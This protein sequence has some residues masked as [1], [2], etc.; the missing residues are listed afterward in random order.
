MLSGQ[1]QPIASYEIGS[2]PQL[3]GLYALRVPLDSVG[4]RLPSTARPGDRAKIFLAKI[5]LDGQLTAEVTIG[6]RGTVQ[7][8]DVDPELAPQP[9]MVSIADVAVVEDQVGPRGVELVISLS[10]ALDEL[11]EVD[12]RTLDGTATAGPDYQADSGRAILNPGEP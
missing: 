6:E 11:V 7:L 2:D 5:F 4:E 8:L 10:R 9:A 3:A 1:T 12:W